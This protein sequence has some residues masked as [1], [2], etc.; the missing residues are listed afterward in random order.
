MPCGVIGSSAD[1]C[2][3][4]KPWAAR[5]ALV[6]SVTPKLPPTPVSAISDTAGKA[7]KWTSL[8]EE[9]LA[10]I[11]KT[12]AQKGVKEYDEVHTWWWLAYDDMLREM[13]AAGEESGWREVDKYVTR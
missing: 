4:D 9:L 8:P 5:P 12:P 10:F 1:P 3:L 2:S 13:Q 6:D 7:P 11:P